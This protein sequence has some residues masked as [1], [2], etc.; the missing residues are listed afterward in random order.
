MV[1]VFFKE[2][3]LGMRGIN[4]GSISLWDTVNFHN[5][6]EKKKERKKNG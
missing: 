3:P 5:W 4:T 1:Q 6:H 2:N